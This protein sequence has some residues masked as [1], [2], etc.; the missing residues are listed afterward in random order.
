MPF[1]RVTQLV[2]HWAK[3]SYDEYGAPTVSTPV[4]LTVRWEQGLSQQIQTAAAPTSVDA[5]VWVDRDIEVGSM[6]R[7][8]ALVDVPG[9]ADEILEV[10]DFQKIPDIKGREFERV[11]LLRKYMELLPTVV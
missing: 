1:D 6:F 8:S 10:V 5:T 7:L 4:E 2:T 9:T 11:V 3:S